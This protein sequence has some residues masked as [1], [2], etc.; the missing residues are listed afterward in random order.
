MT[1]D[2]TNKERKK[3]LPT[4]KSDANYYLASSL[5]PSI[6]NICLFRLDEYR[7]FP[8]S[9]Q[10]VERQNIPLP[11]SNVVQTVLFFM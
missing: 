6:W 3:L 10:V 5:A 7:H 11:V 9:Q 2:M 4:S 1:N 8:I